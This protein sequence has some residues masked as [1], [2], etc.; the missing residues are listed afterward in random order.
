MFPHTMQCLAT[1]IPNEVL[2]K[3]FRIATGVPDP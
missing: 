2:H 3:I 1:P